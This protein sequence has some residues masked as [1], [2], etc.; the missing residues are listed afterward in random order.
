M[1]LGSGTSSLHLGPSTRI[2]VPMVIFTPFGSGIGLCPAL[3]MMP[4]LPKLAENLSPDVF[5]ARRTACH[6][7]ARRGQDA[8]SQAAQHLRDFAAAYINT[9][10]RARHALNPRD[11]R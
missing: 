2:V 8:D 5:L 7:S 3:D 9:A 4:S 6:D 11:H 1:P 10:P